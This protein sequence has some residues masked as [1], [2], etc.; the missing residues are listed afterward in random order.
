MVKPAVLVTGANGLV[1]RAVCNRLHAS[2][3]RVIGF[4]LSHRTVVNHHVDSWVIGDV[5]NRDQL[6]GVIATETVTGIVHLA[7]VSRRG[8]GDQFP[9]L[10]LNRNVLG[11]AALLDAATAVPAKPWVILASTRELTEVATEADTGM[12]AV[13]KRC[14][15]LI[16]AEYARAAKLRVLT[17]RLSDVYGDVHDNPD[18]LLMRLLGDALTGKPLR[19][20]QP[21][22]RRCWTH[23]D[24][25]ARCVVSHAVPRI[26]RWKPGTCRMAPVVHDHTW[27]MHSVAQLISV[28]TGV[29][30]SL[31]RE[32]KRA[33]A[34]HVNDAWRIPTGGLAYRLLGWRARIG[35]DAGIARLWRELKA[36]RDALREA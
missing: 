29:A 30:F 26:K 32:G 27:R 31:R 12:Y 20:D 2:G 9:L 28:E 4:D 7:G 34:Q 10:T 19:I 23:V 36:Q 17:L 25:V 8:Q 14:A 21:D 1:G 6:R 35:L 16:A 33:V 13:S 15:E 22:D 3:H 24:D 18:R 5:R 11:T